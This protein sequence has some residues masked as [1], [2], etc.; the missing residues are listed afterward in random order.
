MCFWFISAQHGFCDI[1]ITCFMRLLR[2]FETYYETFYEMLHKKWSFPLR[3]SSVN[4]TKF[5][6]EI[7]KKEL[8]F[9]CSETYETITCFMRIFFW[10]IG[11]QHGLCDKFITWFMRQIWFWFIL[12]QYD[13][14]DE[15]ITWFVRQ[16]CLWFISV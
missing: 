8:H 4:A 6:E 11:V 2:D 12:V 10:F 9:L 1:F 3:I 7:L 15:F 16:I 13:L 5:T 14:C